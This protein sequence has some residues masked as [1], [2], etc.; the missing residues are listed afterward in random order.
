MPVAMVW[1]HCHTKV[2]L[3]MEKG[4]LLWEVPQDAMMGV[5]ERQLFGKLFLQEEEDSFATV[6]GDPLSLDD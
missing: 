6:E 5:G 3:S 4:S 2:H 1:C